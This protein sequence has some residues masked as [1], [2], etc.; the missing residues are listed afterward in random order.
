MR[1]YNERKVKIIYN[2]LVNENKESK[3]IL[4][5]LKRKRPK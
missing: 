5:L 3:A 1:V 2:D 4:L